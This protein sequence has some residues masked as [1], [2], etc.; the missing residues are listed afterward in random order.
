[1]VSLSKLLGTFSDLTKPYLE[2]TREYYEEM[3]ATHVTNVENDVTNATDYVKWAVDKEGEEKQ[4]ATDV[5]SE[6]VADKVVKILRHE[7]GEKV[8]PRVV[9]KGESSDVEP[10]ADRRH[11]LGRGH[12]PRRHRGAH[13]SVRLRCRV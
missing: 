11:S 2:L 3:A 8:A 9:G 5:F 1:M 7:D 6:E 4:R 10:A 12:V 13:P